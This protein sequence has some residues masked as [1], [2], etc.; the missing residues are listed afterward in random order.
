M[1]IT[2]GT[3]FIE[4]D[5]AAEADVLAVPWQIHND[6]ETL[7]VEGVQAFPLTASEDEVRGFLSRKLKTYKENLAL[8]E[9]SKELQA[10]LDNG[11]AVAEKITGITVTE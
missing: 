5:I 4:R 6:D 10:A 9:G 2:S 3:A 1:R 11:S 8:H 7:A